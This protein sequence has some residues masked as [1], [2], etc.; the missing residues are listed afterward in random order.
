MC[1]PATFEVGPVLKDC[2]LSIKSGNMFAEQRPYH[3]ANYFEK[4]W[5]FPSSNR[6]AFNLL[7]R[8]LL[9][10]VSVRLIGRGSIIDST[11]FAL[12]VWL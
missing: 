9:T 10:I 4:L 2:F 11:E 6:M 8:T 12:T 5:F 7:F 1:W 3:P